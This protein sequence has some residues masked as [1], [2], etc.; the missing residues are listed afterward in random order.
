[1]TPRTKKVLLAAGGALALGLVVLAVLP[2]LFRDRIEARVRAEIER[3][4]RVRVSWSDVGLTFFRD[5]PHPT[6]SLHDLAVVGTGRFDGDTLAAVRTFRLALGAGSVVRALRGSGPLVVRSVRVA[7]PVVNLT[8]DD[9]GTASWDVLP[10]R[11]EESEPGEGADASGRSLAV[12][13]RSFELTDGRVILENERSGLFV[14]L[15]GLR[16]SLNGDFSRESLVASTDLHADRTTLRFAGTPYLA[17]VALD[18][19]ADIDVD[20]TTKRVRL[21]DNELR[22]NELVLAVTGEAGREGEDLA[23]DLEF[24]APSTEFGQL[25]SLVPAVYAADFAS[26]QTSGSFTVR[27]FVRGLYGESAF[28][29][30]A[31]DVT[32][33]DGSFRYPDLPL[34][35]RAITADLSITN[36]GGDIDSTVVNLSRFHVEIGDQAVDGAATLRT[37]VSDPEADVRVR[38]TLDLAD[39]ARTVKLENAPDLSGVIVADAAVRARRSDVDS[40]RYE[41]IAA[42][43]T[44]IATGVTL[45]GEGLRQPVDIQELSIQLSPERA[46]LQAF[47]AQLGSSDLQATGTLDNLLGFVMGDEPLRGAGS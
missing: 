30:L 9:D 41:R 29:A 43:G 42:E 17:G 34:P 18:F 14:S 45:R 22:L 36:P 37:P 5:F 2:F 3:S 1:V 33:E 20:M 24:E 7:E 28:P 40:A 39:V 26:L 44:V 11:D 35:A 27:G 8:V 10:G 19:D 31:L 46:D 12:A 25:L 32:V 13:L 47:R 6:F 21:L 15:E 16:H 38:G 4:S 23:L